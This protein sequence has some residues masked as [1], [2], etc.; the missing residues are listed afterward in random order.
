M[1]PILSISQSHH[2]CHSSLIIDCHSLDGNKF[3]SNKSFKKERQNLLQF[4]ALSIWMSA[5]HAFPFFCSH[6]RA[7]CTLPMWFVDC[8]TQFTI[9]CI[10]DKTIFNVMWCFEKNMR[11]HT[12]TP[13]H[14][15]NTSSNNIVCSDCM[16]RKPAGQLSATGSFTQSSCIE[17]AVKLCKL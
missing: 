15:R 3:T 8:D 17:W 7:Q 13:F 1:H 5:Y 6:M 12:N 2:H 11:F 4:F 14:V 9:Y 10:R 16:I